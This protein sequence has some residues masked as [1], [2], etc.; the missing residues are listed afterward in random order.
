MCFRFSTYSIVKSFLLLVS[1]A[2]F[3]VVIQADNTKEQT[4]PKEVFEKLLWG[5][6]YKEGGTTFYTGKAFSKNTVLITESHVYPA[7]FV[8]DHLDCGT[9]RRCLRTNE[10]YRAIQSD[11]HNV[12]IAESRLDLKIKSSIFGILDESTAKDK[13]GMRIHLNVIEPQDTLKGDIARIIFYMHDRYDLPIPGRLA[14]L[15][16]WNEQDPPST[17]EIERNNRIE[18]LQGHRNPFVDHPERF[19]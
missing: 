12:V 5:E 1:C 7:I 8:R 17:E 18:A 16:L 14:D 19:P 13:H 6:L 11:L 2:L 9:K 15:S 3:S 4:L 10:Q